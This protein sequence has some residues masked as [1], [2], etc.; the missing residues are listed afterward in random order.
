MGTV[1]LH[2]LNDQHPQTSKKTNYYL[3]TALE[4][5]KMKAFLKV[6]LIVALILDLTSSFC[7]ARSRLGGRNGRSRF[8]RF[9]RSDPSLE[10]EVEEEPDYDDDYDAFLDSLADVIIDKQY[11]RNLSSL[12]RNRDLRNLSSMHGKRSMMNPLAKNKGLGK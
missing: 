7:I 6:L 11:K 4:K 3:N 9:G 12:V 10:N 8:G 5:H 1:S 2:T